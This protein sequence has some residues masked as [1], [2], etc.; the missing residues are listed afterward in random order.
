MALETN[1][2]S[3]PYFDDYDEFKDF[4]RILF[5][6]G[7]SVQTRELNQ[8][9]T[10]LQKQIE[11]F[12]DHI[13]K[14]G[15]IVSGVNFSYNSLLPY[16]KLRDLQEDGQPVNTSLYNG[17][18][19]KSTANLQARVVNYESGFE[20][21]NPNLHTLYL[22]YVNAGNTFNLSAYSNDDVLEVFNVDNRIY[23]VDV[24]N[25][26]SGFA[27]SD[28]LVIVP[29]INV[30]VSSGTFTNGEIVTQSTS[31]ARV[32]IVGIFNGET[33]SQKILRVKPINA[34]Q[35]SNT[36]AN[37][38]SW[39]I[40]TGYN[41]QGNTSSAVA[42][43]TSSVVGNTAANGVVVTDS[44]GVVQN[45]VLS[46]GGSGYTTLPTA[47]IK[48]ASA[49]AG[50]GSLDLSARSYLAKIRVAN[51]SFTA[52]VG[53]GYSFSI[54]E[55]V[56]YQK[57]VF[58]RVIP[59][60]VI[61]S[62][63]SSSPANVS[64]GFTSDESIVKYTTD[65]TLYDN[66]SNTF[67]YS[68]PGAD[69]LRIRPKL[70]VVNSNTASSNSEFLPL[71]EFVDGRPAK[72]NR[73]TVYNTLSREYERRTFETAGNFVINSFDTTTKE[74]DSNTTHF[75]IVIDPGTA[76][77][78]GK[79]INTIG[80]I[81]KTAEKANN[82]LS[83]TNQTITA[84]YGNYVKVKE[85]VGFFDFKAGANVSFYDTAQTTLT[86]VT[87]SS[88]SAIS[89]SGNLIGSARIR[90]I[91]YE[92]GTPGTPE[93]IYR[94]Y[95]FDIS[96][97]TGKSFRDVRSIYF[98][99]SYDGICDTVQE[100]ITSITEL[101]SVLYKQPY[102][103]LQSTSGS[104]S[105]TQY[106]TALMEYYV[107][108]SP[109]VAGL[110][111]W[112]DAIQ[113]STY[114]RTQ[115][116]QFIANGEYRTELTN[117]VGSLIYDTE[118][119]DVIFKTGVSSVKSISDV[120]YTY[121]TSTENLTLNANGTIEITAPVTYT[122]PYSGSITLSQSQKQ[123]FVIAPVSNTQTSNTT[124]TVSGNTTSRVLTGTSTTFTSDYN[125]G[126]HIVIYNSPS[127]VNVRRIENIVNSTSM[128]INAN[129]AFTNA[130]SNAALF[131]PAYYPIDI[132]RTSRNITTS[133]NA[134]VVTVNINATLSAS[135]NVVAYYNIKIPSATQINKDLNRDLYVKI[136]TG[137]NVTLS[138]S[139]NNTTGPWSLGIPDVFRLKN[140]YYGNTTSNTDITKYFYVN[141]YDD[142]DKVKNAQLNL[143]KGA[144]LEISNTQWLLVQFDAFDVN[145]SEGFIT[146][147]SYNDII[148]DT[149][150]Y[151]NNTYINLLEVPELLTEGRYFDGRDSFD[152]RPF[153]TNTAVFTSTVAS[154]TVNPANSQVL[155]SDEKYFPAPDSEI[156]F[157]IE[158][159]VPRIDR[160]VVFSNGT[161][162]VIKG[163]SDF[164]GFKTPPTPGDSL[165][166]S[167]VFIPPYP[168]IPY[169]IGNT[170]FNI[171]DKKV[172]NDSGI[173][174]NRKDQYQI[175]NIQ[176]AGNSKSTAV[177]PYTFER[178]SKLE[179]RIQNIEKQILLNN[180]E[181][182]I[183]EQN[184]PSFVDSSK[185]RFK[186][187]FVVDSFV[188]R[189]VVD[190]NSAENSC[191]INTLV[192]ELQ[193][194]KLSYNIEGIFDRSDTS[195]TTPAITNNIQLMLPY[196][197]VTL[198]S[199]LNASKPKVIPILSEPVGEI[200]IPPSTN[201]TTDSGTT[202]VDNIVVD[203]NIY[204]EQGGTSD[205]TTGTG[206]EVIVLPT[207]VVTRQNLTFQKPFADLN[208]TLSNYTNEAFI[209]QLYYYYLARRPD[210]AG[211]EY[212][213]S[214]LNGGLDS[215]NNVELNFA[216]G[217]T[218]AAFVY[219][220]YVEYIL[221]PE[222][223]IGLLTFDEV[224]ATFVTEMYIPSTPPP[225]SGG[226]SLFEPVSETIITFAGLN[227]V[228]STQN[229]VLIT[230]N[231]K[232]IG[233]VTGV[234]TTSTVT[235]DSNQK[236]E[237]LVNNGFI[238]SSKASELDSGTVNWLIDYYE[239]KNGTIQGST[240]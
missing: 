60:T 157:D 112:V 185:N 66:A 58:S 221:A 107:S 211:F 84:N 170:F 56:I 65:E 139:G 23:D 240:N 45:I 223:T 25:G 200:N 34:E 217:E 14:S 71:V 70:V 53:F 82:Y 74:I 63:Y 219:D 238:P 73:D 183:L 114:T 239:S 88:G 152:F 5:K 78:S 125:V 195:N 35:L 3:T 228:E 6:P 193:P 117:P 19:L 10:I 131:F 214:I 64:V 180:L 224:A 206:A 172:G 190:L 205:Q 189:D 213:V 120:S 201:P 118:R 187:G 154:A 199:Q 43:V 93:A 48:P 122:F 225:P 151:S 175:K 127:S 203:T 181:K 90:S 202:K 111:F 148:N 165:S 31:G 21:Q 168:S 158:Y 235:L 8:L 100:K 59:Q 29:A 85:F 41:I 126:D 136:Y 54:T 49:S 86:N 38:T 184:I 207:P 121:R 20:S 16:I 178:I 30:S 9:Q 99:G 147:N 61:V 144:N 83:K 42:N 13:F 24:V 47:V 72:E 94:L 26:G 91:V 46:T 36:S 163:T 176:S 101:S 186:H 197:E 209:V 89:P 141:S 128:V 179:R 108:R 140:V 161:F 171:L 160:T 68:A 149:S 39:T 75:N 196:S 194:L 204:P 105:N 18:R 103:N 123:D 232:A 92:D 87:V 142:G 69:R 116:E 124:G 1:L 155:N 28:T 32:Q 96:M 164:N 15:T 81:F 210:S 191:F 173:V 230:G 40:V 167:E 51:S 216:K 192:N 188:N 231:E 215:R 133:A 218:R 226:I 27:N 95:L 236:L 166:I 135:A 104:L 212:W 79:R 109:D 57:G 7:V 143:I 102:K 77:I 17:L 106:V 138:S 115:V 129:L 159:Y 52:P 198:I 145:S 146:I 37:S 169:N 153:V 130:T 33:A 137:N 76:Y 67:N 227:T 113:A 110:R 98:D 156:Q 55:G 22:N 229:Q 50:V 233:E 162:D 222:Y 12:G 44:L 177:L 97:N 237:I 220:D 4:Y 62:K 11:R 132:L 150:G 80:N 134:A 119:P 208:S 234:L 182:S 174:Y 2:N